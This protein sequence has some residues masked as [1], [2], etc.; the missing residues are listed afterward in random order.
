[1]GT[2]IKNSMFLEGVVVYEVIN[3]LNN[4]KYKMPFDCYGMNMKLLKKI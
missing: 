2:S 4:C 1:M 3:T